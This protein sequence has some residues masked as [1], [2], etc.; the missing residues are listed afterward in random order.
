VQF[1]K[2]ETVNDGESFVFVCSLR[3]LKQL[4]MANHLFCWLMY[5]A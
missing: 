4:T 2:I 5:T 1:E 3:R